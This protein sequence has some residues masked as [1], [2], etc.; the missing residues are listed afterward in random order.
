MT[1][2]TQTEGTVQTATETLTSPPPF[3]DGFQNAEAKEWASKGGFKSPEDVAL[4]ARE[5]ETVAKKFEAF[6]DADPQNLALLKADAKPEEHMALLQKLG[7]PQEAAAYGLD[8]IEGVDPDLATNAQGW[9]QEAG[10]LPW[11]ARLLADKQMAYMNA[12]AEAAQKAGQAAAARELAALKTEWGQEY[13]AKVDLGRRALKVAGQATGLGQDKVAE[14]VAD[15]ESSFGAGDAMK[16]FSFFGQF[17]KE[18][19]FV[20]GKGGGQAPASI[21]DRWYPDT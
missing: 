18:S 2:A 16:F 4:K 8:K 1:T 15:I 6:K 14:I 12:Q 19:D 3:Y 17:V 9:F 21:A 5:Y 10:L 20:D 11:Q 13:D 7:A